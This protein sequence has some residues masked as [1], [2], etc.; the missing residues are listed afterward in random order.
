MRDLYTISSYVSVILKL[1]LPSV[2]TLKVFSICIF[3][4]KYIYHDSQLWNCWQSSQYSGRYYDCNKAI[5]LSQFLP[6]KTRDFTSSLSGEEQ[7]KQMKSLRTVA[8]SVAPGACTLIWWKPGEIVKE[9]QLEIMQALQ[10]LILK[11]SVSI[12]SGARTFFFCTDKSGSLSVF[13][14]ASHG[15]YKT[16]QCYWPH[17]IIATREFR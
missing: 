9:L 8:D 13:C 17:Q 15:N 7:R 14:H 12:T 6:P 2:A 4:E 5:S 10:R 16:L 11:K 1:C 3:K